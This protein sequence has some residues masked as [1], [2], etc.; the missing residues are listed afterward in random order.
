MPKDNRHC[1]ETA[2]RL[3]QEQAP[4]GWKV[5]DGFSSQNSWFSEGDNH[6]AEGNMYKWN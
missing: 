6:Y 4:E 1:K 5:I 3:A 2:K